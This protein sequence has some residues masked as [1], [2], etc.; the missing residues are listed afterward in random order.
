MSATVVGRRAFGRLVSHRHCQLGDHAAVVDRRAMRGARARRRARSGRRARASRTSAAVRAPTTIRWRPKWPGPPATCDGATLAERALGALG[1][2]EVLVQAR[3]MAIAAD[4]AREQGQ[5]R[6]ARKRYDAAFQRDPGIF[7]RLEI[8]VGVEIRARGGG[9]AARTSPACSRA[10]RASWRC[11]AGCSCR[12]RSRAHL[13]ACAWRRAGPGH[14]VRRDRRQQAQARRRATPRTS[15]ERRCPAVLAAR[16]SD[17]RWR[18]TRSTVKTLP[19]ATRSRAVRVATA[20]RLRPDRAI[21]RKRRPGSPGTC[22]PCRRRC[23]R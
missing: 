5:L 17:A 18:S 7:R 9:V 11:R 13:R 4:I 6:R 20:P 2:S 10:R 21:C 8:P 14:L 19:A 3:V 22:P 15:H 23:D 1:T 16:R 12:S